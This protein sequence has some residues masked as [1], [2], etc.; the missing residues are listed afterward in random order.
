MAFWNSVAAMNLCYRLS[1][2]ALL[3]TSGGLEAGRGKKGA[4]EN[5]VMECSEERS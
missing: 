1:E 5:G 2:I 3:E 4:P